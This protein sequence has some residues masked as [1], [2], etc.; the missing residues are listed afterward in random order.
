VA[1]APGPKRPL[2]EV[3][4][5]GNEQLPTDRLR[6]VMRTAPR[7]ALSTGTGVLVDAWLEEDMASLRALYALEGFSQAEI[8]PARVLP[9]DDHLELAIP[10]V[11]GRRRLVSGVT[12]EG[13]HQFAHEEVL[14]SLPLR[15]GGPYHVRREEEALDRLR[16]RYEDEGFGLAQVSARRQI[17]DDGALVQVTIQVLEGPLHRVERVI[18]RG[19]QKTRPQVIRRVLALEP[20]TPVSQRLLLELQRR[21]YGLGIFSRVDV[22]L[23]P[24]TPYAAGRDVMVEVKEGRSQRVTYGLGYDSEDGARGLLG[25]GHSNLW[26]RAIS[27]RVD[28]RASQR[29]YQARALL[30]Q[31]YVGRFRLPLT[32]SLFDIEQ[33]QESFRSR[34]RGAQIELQ[35][36]REH[37]RL[38]LLYTYKLVAI[39]DPD[40]GL[41]PLLIER[42]FQEATI[43][44]ITPS[45]FLDYRDDAVDPTRGWSA[46]LLTEFA[47]PVFAAEEEFLK[48]FVQHTRYWSLHRAGVVAVSLRGGAIEP[49]GN[50]GSPDPVCAENGLDFP[51]CGV[52]ISERFFAGGRTSHR[53]YRRDRLGIPG[54]RLNVN[55]G[56]IAVGHP[57]GVSGARLTGHALIEGKRRG[58]KYVVVTMCVGGGMGAAGLFEVV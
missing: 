3:E 16:A 5:L 40:P 18:V 58:E 19:Q 56:A 31:P 52:K 38:S 20:G 14:A 8:G 49:L 57:Y 33:Q 11:E 25:Y 47:F 26:G 37:S 50:G 55:G 54:D 46:T 9:V 42:A 10:I 29:D 53:A 41:E 28:V 48:G 51:S 45:V 35:R 36:P 39:E 6:S 44:S 32:A 23:V 2:R 1:V 21:L 15:P 27:G 43:G 4:F 30:R 13:V 12:L 24:G 7:S 34:R 17:S 22:T